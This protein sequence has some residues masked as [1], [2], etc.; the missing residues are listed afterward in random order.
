[1]KKEHLRKVYNTIY[2][3][4]LLWFS[5]MSYYS[6][7]SVLPSQFGYG[8]VFWLFH[9]IIFLILVLLNHF[10]KWLIQAVF[11]FYFLFLEL[12]L[13]VPWGNYIFLALLC[14]SIMTLFFTRKIRIDIKTSAVGLAIS[15]IW[16]FFSYCFDL[17]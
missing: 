15:I 7:S 9:I 1:M 16:V 14:I 4:T 11:I 10:H 2:A 3:L 12:F 17:W 5:F 8:F 6:I 13:R